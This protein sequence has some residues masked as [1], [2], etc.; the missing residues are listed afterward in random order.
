ME[1]L[2]SAV[3]DITW[4]MATAHALRIPRTTG[5]APPGLRG[6]RRL[7][8]ELR[9]GAIA[10]LKL[11]ARSEQAMADAQLLAACRLAAEHRMPRAIAEADRLRTL[12]TEQPGALDGLAVVRHDLWRLAH[13]TIHVRRDA[14]VFAA[15]R[16]DAEGRAVRKVARRLGKRLRKALIAYVRAGMRSGGAT[17]GR[18]ARLRQ[19]ALSGL[20]AGR[21]ADAA[22]SARSARELPVA[23][24]VLGPGI[25]RALTDLRIDWGGARPDGD[26]RKQ[27]STAATR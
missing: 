23:P 20:S 21:A 19:A 18:V 11:L 3:V 16:G 6:R 5:D 4:L 2:E 27:D 12:M 7:R 26:H 25:E 1:L 9:R 22:H 14:G 10:Y 8:D 24:L 17:E 13:L 15:G